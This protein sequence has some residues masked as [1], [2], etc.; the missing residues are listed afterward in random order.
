M[1]K[2]LSLFGLLT[3]FVLILSCEKDEE[4]TLEKESAVSSQIETI[5]SSGSFQNFK[6]NPKFQEAVSIL[7]GIS[8]SSQQNQVARGVPGD[9]YVQGFQVDTSYVTETLYENITSYT[10]LIQPDLNQL[11]EFE[12]LVIQFDDRDNSLTSLVKYSP[13]DISSFN[14]AFNGTM[15]VTTPID[16]EI[17]IAGFQVDQ[18]VDCIK[19]VVSG[20]IDHVP[21]GVCGGSY[22][23]IIWDC[24]GGTSDTY[25]APIYTGPANPTPKPVEITST[26]GMPQVVTDPITPFYFIEFMPISTRHNYFKL[27]EEQ[28]S[29]I[30]SFLFLNQLSPQALPF[31]QIMIDYLV[32]NPNTSVEDLLNNRN[33]LN[34]TSNGDINNNSPA[35]NIDTPIYSDFD[36]LQEEWSSIESVISTDDFVGWRTEYVTM[37]DGSTRTLS[38]M[39]FAKEQIAVEGYEISNYFNNENQTIQIYTESG[40]VDSSAVDDAISYLKAALEENIPVIVGIDNHSG[41]PNP[42]TDNSTDHFVVIVGMGSDANGDYFLFFDNASEHVNQGASSENKLY[43]DPINKTI[44]GESQVE[45]YTNCCTE[46]D[47]KVTQI[48]KSK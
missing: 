47:Y 19:I 3:V 44:T 36:Y 15:E 22:S 27:T 40:G 20:C 16:G 8:S 39:D 1:K 23:E 28:R 25:H 5:T 12:N 45:W 41:S 13:E 31:A 42:N 34:S 11:D 33:S 37:S 48:R 29:D 9:A 17:F 7:N 6:D 46:Y 4:I 21:G 32:D 38:C 18:E 35:P 14:T 43:F 10:F 2:L 26:I 30:G 24:G